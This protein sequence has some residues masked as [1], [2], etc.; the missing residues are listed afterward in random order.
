MHSRTGF[1]KYVQTH[2]VFQLFHLLLVLLDLLVAIF[3]LNKLKK[4]T[5]DKVTSDLVQSASYVT[6]YLF[7]L[8]NSMIH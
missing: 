8:T 3:Q 2:L 4:P 5:K 6:L 7:S 1:Y